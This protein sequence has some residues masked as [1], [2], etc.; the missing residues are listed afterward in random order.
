MSIKKQTTGPGEHTGSDGQSK[1]STM[2]Y[3]SKKAVEYDLE[4]H[5]RLQKQYLDKCDELSGTDGFLIKEK[6]T[7]SGK[8]FYSIKKPGDSRYIYAGN[9]DTSEV[10]KIRE[11]RLYKETLIVIE[12][13]IR[14]MEDF[15]SVYRETRVENITELLPRV[16]KLPHDAVR[17]SL[18][19][20][21]DNWLKEKQKIK[22]SYPV[23]NPAGLTCRAFDGTM[24]RSRAECVHY[25]A[26]FLY[27]VPSIFELPYETANDVLSPDF[28]A[29]DVFTME[30]KAFEHLG[31]WFHKDLVKRRQYRT[32]SIDRWDQFRQLGFVP[33]VNL[34]LTFGSGDSSFDAQAIHRKIAMLASPPPSKETIEM[35]RRL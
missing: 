33:E 5:Y 14:A 32:E 31:N 9:A 2:R 8:P 25:E 22:D 18:E 34:L 10:Q 30:S 21:V 35:L 20:E 27:D 1:E 15:L 4:Q 16:Y 19:P 29:L 7:R 11:N 23:F 28:T 24:M 26:F 3:T 12:R 13:N 17:M 6:K